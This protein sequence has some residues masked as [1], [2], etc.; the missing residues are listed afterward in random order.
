MQ[1]SVDRKIALTLKNLETIQEKKLL[2]LI[3]TFGKISPMWTPA[4]Q[5]ALR[6]GFYTNSFQTLAF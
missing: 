1:K 3:M 5:I 6:L 2:R 4:E